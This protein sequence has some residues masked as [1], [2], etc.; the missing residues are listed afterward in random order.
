MSDDR[1]VELKSYR[2]YIAVEQ[3]DLDF[4]EAIRE[5]YAENGPVVSLIAEFREQ[6]QR[7]DPSIAMLKAAGEALEEAQAT[8]LMMQQHCE[9]NWVATPR[10]M[11][12]QCKA[13]K[14]I[15]NT[16]A[17]LKQPGGR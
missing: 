12:K 17:S 16:L 6:F 15:D 7:A 5:A 13:L 14:K 11:E 1:V 4:E 10:V 2:G 8:I 9:M 3:C